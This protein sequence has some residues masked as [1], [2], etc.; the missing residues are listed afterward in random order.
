MLTHVFRQKDQG[1][2][3]SEQARDGLFVRS[4]NACVCGLGLEFASMLNEMRLNQMSSR[5]MDK[6]KS[7]ARTP[8]YADSSIEPTRL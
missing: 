6:F 4:N 1:K 2:E 7:L 5:T 8:S 3:P